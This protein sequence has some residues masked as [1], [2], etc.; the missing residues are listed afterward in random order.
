MSDEKG[1]GLLYE[2]VKQCPYCQGPVDRFGFRPK[3]VRIIRGLNS[4]A[5]VDRQI[6]R[7]RDLEKYGATAYFECRDCGSMGDPTIGMMTPPMPKEMR[8]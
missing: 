3:S 4:Q 2:N 5:S 7:A 6:E 8:A 1:P